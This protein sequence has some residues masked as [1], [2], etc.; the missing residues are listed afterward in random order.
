MLLATS[1]KLIV[2]IWLFLLFFA[3][4]MVILTF[5]IHFIFKIFILNF[6]FCEIMPMKKMLVTKV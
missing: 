5:K 6:F 2:E 4:F 3:P 1:L